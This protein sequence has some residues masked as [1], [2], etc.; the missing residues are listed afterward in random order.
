MLLPAEKRALDLLSDW[1]WLSRGEL[2]D[3]LDVSEPRVSQ[4][5]VSLE[6]CGLAVRPRGTGGRMA[7]SD[8]GLA[9]LARRDRTSVSAARKRWS[10]SPV[11]ESAPL[12]WRN[13]SGG[14]SR[15]L[16][17]NLDHTAA[18]HG[19]I[20]DLAVQA[21]ALGWETA[22][23][24]PPHR[25]SRHFPAPGRPALRPPRCLRAPAP[26]LA[27]LGLLPGVGAQ[28]R[29]ARH[30]GPAPGPIPALLLYPQAHRRPRRSAPTSWWSSTTTSPPATSS[31]WRSG[32]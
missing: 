2:A 11:D 12:H 9:L 7:L 23:L 20:A 5:A 25:A 30:H 32:R 17:R 18:V 14:R 6:G 1:P 19:F 15:Q 22:Q 3:L 31:G 28:G 29:P 27:D 21:R 8:T 26:R 4:L 24:D 16:L 13:V 10:V